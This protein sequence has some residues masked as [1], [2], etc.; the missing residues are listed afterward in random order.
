MKRVF[1]A[2]LIA[3]A[4]LTAAA[5]GDQRSA[6]TET[7]IEAKKNGA[8]V[9]TIVEEFTEEYY[10]LDDLTQM[11]TEAC[12]TYNQTAGEGSVIVESAE[13]EDGVLTA[14]MRY[15]DAADYT[16][17]N[18]LP[19]FSGTV[20]EAV[21]AGYNMNVKLYPADGGEVPIGKEELL[22]MGDSHL[23]ILREE[24]DVDVWDDVLYHTA[25]VMSTSDPRRVKVLNDRTLTFI[26]FE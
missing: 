1:C 22:E 13:L 7:T 17:F 12:E 15:E 26:V 14:V 9:H 24:M 25:N 19:M 6:V 23:V 5:C 21:N 10:S 4:A 2:A 16:A 3:A 11:M 20:Q 8:I 18:G